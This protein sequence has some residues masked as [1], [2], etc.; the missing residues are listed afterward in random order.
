M[1]QLRGSR[2]AFADDGEPGLGLVL[3][4]LARAA[5]SD[6]ELE[7]AALGAAESLNA[8]FRRTVRRLEDAA[9]LA[10]NNRTEI[11]ELRKALRTRT[12]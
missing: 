6:G 3:H 11:N 1:R 5:G 2:R 4:A 7:R 9:L 8:V 12:A 10:Q